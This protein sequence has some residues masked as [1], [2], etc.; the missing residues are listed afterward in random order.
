MAARLPLVIR[1]IVSGYTGGNQRVSFICIRERVDAGLGPVLES[2]LREVVGPQ[3]AMRYRRDR[4]R[5][6][7]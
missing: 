4:V 2:A 5:S 1:H 7:L 3:I 6:D